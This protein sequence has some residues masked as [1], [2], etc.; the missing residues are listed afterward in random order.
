MLNPFGLRVALTGSAMPGRLLPTRVKLGIPR[1]IGLCIR[2]GAVLSV[3]LGVAAPVALA[4]LPEQH[5][6]RLRFAVSVDGRNLGTHEFSFNTT[7]AGLEVVSTARLDFR[8]AF[9]SLFKYRHESRELWGDRCLHSFSSTTNDNG[10]RYRVSAAAASDGLHLEREL[11]SGKAAA[12]ERLFANERSYCAATFAYWDIDRVRNDSLI[13]AQT[14]ELTAI[15]FEELDQET[16]DGEQRRH[17]V[18]RPANAPPIHLW[19]SAADDRWLRL[20]N[21][22]EDGLLIYTAVPL[23]N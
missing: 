4:A 3:A 9:I 2:L 5:P 1:T 10:K 17:V 15:A 20:E 8:I 11:P 18:L 7:A 16:V 21:E 14:G 23:T 13:N 22:T 6:E 19:Y 12:G